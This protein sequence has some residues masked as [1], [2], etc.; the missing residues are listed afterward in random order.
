MNPKRPFAA[1]SLVAALFLSVAVGAC[2]TSQ[3]SQPPPP[4]G[5]IGAPE[6]VAPPPPPAPVPV[7]TP[8]PLPSPTGTPISDY[9]SIIKL[10]QANISEDF[11]LQRIREES[12]SYDLSADQM[13]ELRNAGVSE[14]VIQ[15]MMDTGREVASAT[16][17][18]PPGSAPIGRPVP[19]DTMSVSARAAAPS[20]P[21]SEVKWEGVV[22]RHGGV[23]V[24][25]GRWDS[26]TLS[27]AD[28]QI[29]WL[30]AK[31]SSNNL[32]I[33][34][35]AVKEQFLTCLKKPGGNECF[36][37][38]FRTINGDEYR[39]RDVAWEQGVNDKVLA[40]HDFFKTRFPALVDSMIPVDKK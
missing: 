21:A 10:W 12:R 4:S 29:R 26:G 3:T 33:P 2:S 9:R 18:S 23:V 1:G 11:I 17:A 16:P 13:I 39:F 15:A 7:M 32:L 25:R 27:Y 6:P 19:E 5:P 40:I 30:D 38:G 28:G 20:T 22:R 34:D 35:R 31:D 37:W 24:F 8:A 14:K 36:E